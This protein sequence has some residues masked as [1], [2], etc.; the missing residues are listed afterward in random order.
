MDLRSRL[1]MLSC[2]NGK[3][4]VLQGL[5]FS[6]LFRGAQS[7]GR[8]GDLDCKGARHASPCGKSR[9]GFKLEVHAECGN[10]H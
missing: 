1:E 9:W 6:L 4:P 8:H 7:N 5:S 3:S 2:F 10:R